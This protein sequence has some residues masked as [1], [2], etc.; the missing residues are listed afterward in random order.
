MAKRPVVNIDMEGDSEDLSTILHNQ[1]VADLSWLDIN[2]EDYRSLEALPKQNYDVIPELQKALVYTENDDV[3]H[4]IP[5]K[6]HTVVNRN[7]IDVDREKSN[8]NLIEPIRN[9]VASMVMEGLP[10]SVIGTRLSLE[11]SDADIRLASKEIQKVFNERGVLGNIYINSSHFPRCSQ[12]TVKDRK[13]VATHGKRSL[14][15]L[16]NSNCSGCVHNNS[17]ICSTFKKTIVDEVPYTTETLA[18]YSLELSSENRLQDIS[19]ALSNPTPTT[20]KSFLSSSFKAPINSPQSGDVQKIHTQPKQK[21]Y[22]PTK[23]DVSSFLERNAKAWKEETRLSS[24]YLKF[25]KRMCERRDDRP[26]LVNSGDPELTKLSS[27]FGILGH[28]YLDMDAL[29]GCNKT[30]DLIKSRNLHELNDVP[31]FVIRRSS[32]CSHCKN[33]EDGACAQICKISAIL[34]DRPKIDR[35]HFVSSLRRTFNKGRISSEYV[36]KA[37]EKSVDFVN[38]DALTAQANTYTAEVPSNSAYS[39]SLQSSYIG[40]R[41]ASSNSDIDEETVRKDISHMMNTGLHGRDLMSS[42][43][44]KYDKSDLKKFPRVGSIASRNDGI[45]GQYFIDPTA[46]SDYGSGC[47]KGSKLFRKRGALNVL[48]SSSCLG[49]SLQTAPGWCSKYSKDLIEYVPEEVRV[50]SKNSKIALPVIQPKYENLVEKW[51]LGSDVEFNVSKASKPKV[52][53]EVDD[54]DPDLKDL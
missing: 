20:I 52:H 45:Q 33:S 32:S 14:Y 21:K 11:F 46:Y 17:G 38:Y 37:L 3:P 24:S 26:Y 44:S 10:N 23:Q 51:D 1:G 54:D 31:D 9:R 43:L 15:V 12:S 39:G 29:G 13:F 16:A 53:I 5:L 25:A 42:I 35:N 28:T 34:P 47:S 50:A 4:I 7:P 6:P 40:D 2:E 30:L 22:V 27:E 49:C 41:N 48:A 8:P 36:K 19:K 18:H